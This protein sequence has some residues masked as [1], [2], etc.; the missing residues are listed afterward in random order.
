M[1]HPRERPRAAVTVTVVRQA[2]NVDRVAFR[3]K[4]AAQL[5]ELLG[6]VG[7]AVKE[8]D[9]ALCR[10][11]V[12]EQARIAFGG[13]ASVAAF[14]SLKPLDGGTSLSEAHARFLRYDFGGNSFSGQVRPGKPRRFNAE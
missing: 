6:A 13:D 1:R 10:N 5:G 8:D 12:L 2:R 7:E 9:R 11:A 14:E 3:M 4:A